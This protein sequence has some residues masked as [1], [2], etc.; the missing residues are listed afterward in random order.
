MKI[1]G[2]NLYSEDIK[3]YILYKNVKK[4]RKQRLGEDNPGKCDKC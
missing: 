2:I 3:P 4:P 1:R